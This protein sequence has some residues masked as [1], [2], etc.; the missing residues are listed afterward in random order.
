MENEVWKTINGFGDYKISSLGRV[1]SFHK[2]K[3]N[4]KIMSLNLKANGYLEVIL[5]N[6]GKR[7]HKYIHRLVASYFIEGVPK[8]DVNHINEVKTDNRVE[9][10]QWLDHKENINYGSC[11][12]KRSAKRN[13]PIVVVHPD[14]KTEILK[15]INFASEKLSI[16]CNSITKV[17]RGKKDKVKGFTFIYRNSEYEHAI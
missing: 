4:G 15:S 10:L 6:N 13:K 16:S 17:L 12:S 2:D 1:R 3:L 11:I 8:S 5:F 14:G 9:N 7:T